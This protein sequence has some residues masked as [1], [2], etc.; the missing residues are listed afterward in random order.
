MQTMTLF[1]SG[2][3]ADWIYLFA[4]VVNSHQTIESV[5]FLALSGCLTQQL[6][7][8][9]CCQQQEISIP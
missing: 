4:A 1:I 5:S 8:L 7:L 3:T 6:F 2:M 9:S